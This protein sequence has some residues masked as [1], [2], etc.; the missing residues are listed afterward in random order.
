[1]HVNLTKKGRCTKIEMQFNV[2][3]FSTPLVNKYTWWNWKP[4]NN[5]LQ[6]FWD[7]IEVCLPNYGLSY[8][9]GWLMSYLRYLFLFTYSGVQQILCSIFVLVC[10]RLVCPVLPVFLD[11][12]FLIAPSCCQFLWIVHFWLPLR[13]ASFSRF[14]IFDFPFVLPVSLDCPFLIAPSCYKFL[15]IAY[16]WLPLI[17]CNEFNTN[18]HLFSY[19]NIFELFDLILLFPVY[20]ISVSI[21]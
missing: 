2:F 13:V 18:I 6:T 20:L 12:P 5:S 21:F 1:M 8:F 16:F 19:W 11:C 15:W 17:Y 4:E 14:S 9:A 10:L 3:N 7:S